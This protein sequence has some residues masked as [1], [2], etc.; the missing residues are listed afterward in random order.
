M[1]LDI[2]TSPK[3]MEKIDVD[4]ERDLHTGF[5][6]LP[7][8]HQLAARVRPKVV[9]MLQRSISKRQERKKKDP[10]PVTPVEVW[11]A[12]LHF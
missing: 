2:K 6:T 11:M 7:N 1:K 5:P 4:T 12:H 9:A 10:E 3:T 8:N